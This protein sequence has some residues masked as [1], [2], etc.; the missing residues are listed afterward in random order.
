[1]KT[2]RLKAKHSSFCTMSVSP[3]TI[4]GSRRTEQENGGSDLHFYSS[5][6]CPHSER[7][8]Q[9]SKYLGP[10]EDWLD[11]A[12]WGLPSCEQEH[13]HTAGREDLLSPA[14]NHC[15]KCGSNLLTFPNNH[16]LF[17]HPGWLACSSTPSQSLTYLQNALLQMYNMQDTLEARGREADPHSQL[18]TVSGG[19]DQGLLYLG[20]DIQ[21]WPFV[22]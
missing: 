19:I 22:V 4:S 16:S 9:R 12:V 15:S 10:Q 8:S 13:N 2:N 5:F 11:W 3:T 7:I 1:M 17:S 6:V 21:R 20:L 18:S 14:S